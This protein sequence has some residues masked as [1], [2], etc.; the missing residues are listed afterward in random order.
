MKQA[1]VKEKV[2]KILDGNYNLQL[3]S[4][5]NRLY[6]ADQISHAVTGGTV[7]DSKLPI[8][9]KDGKKPV[10]NYDFGM[11]GVLTNT[12]SPEYIKRMEEKESKNE[13]KKIPKNKKETLDVPS[14]PNELNLDKNFVPSKKTKLPKSKSKSTKNPIKNLKNLGKK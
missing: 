5:K 12:Q 8:Q 1:E 13:K 7:S 6:L 10:N 3:Y 14:T 11:G 4:Q 2:I 9:N